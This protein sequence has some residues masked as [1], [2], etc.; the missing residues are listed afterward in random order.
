MIFYAKAEGHI[1]DGD[2]LNALFS[3]DPPGKYHTGNLGGCQACCCPV[4]EE[5]ALEDQGTTL[6][7][8]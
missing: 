6:N 1:K 3:Y 4:F 2:N 8:T 7:R 5:K